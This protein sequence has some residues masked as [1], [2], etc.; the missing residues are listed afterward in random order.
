MKKKGIIMIITLS[1]TPASVAILW[2][3]ASAMGDLHIFPVKRHKDES[4]T[5]SHGD[6]AGPKYRNI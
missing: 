4:M 3:T 1:M 6:G 5:I 2:N